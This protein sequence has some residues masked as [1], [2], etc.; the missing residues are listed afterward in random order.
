MEKQVVYT[1][2]AKGLTEAIGKTKELSRGLRDILKQIDG[3]ANLAELQAGLGNLSDKK[4][5]RALDHLLK[6]HYIRIFDAPRQSK[7]VA[8]AAASTTAPS[9]DDF[10]FS[11]I[12]TFQESLLQLTMSAFENAV[13]AQKLA[14]AQAADNGSKKNVDA[15]IVAQ[16]PKSIIAIDPNIQALAEYTVRLEAEARAKRAA[17][18]AALAKTDNAQVARIAGGQEKTN[19]VQA[20]K[21]SSTSNTSASPNPTIGAQHNVAKQV[22]AHVHQPIRKETELY[23][24]GIRPEEQEEIKRGQMTEKRGQNDHAH[25]SNQAKAEESARKESEINAKH[26]AEELQRRV[27]QGRARM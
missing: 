27:A 6:G 2:T 25:A 3:R 19:R 20:V 18:D 5:E 21:T 9:I 15:N 4:L 22:P 7:K 11:T 26:V 8:S 10:D 1:K 13:E 14:A 16:L 12:G 17:R 23:L 24:G